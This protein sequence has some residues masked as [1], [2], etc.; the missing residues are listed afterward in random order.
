M[1]VFGNTFEI[2]CVSCGE[3]APH[4]VSYAGQEICHLHCS[5]CRAVNAYL[6]GPEGEKKVGEHQDHS[7]LMEP[8]GKKDQAYS[9][10]MAFTDGQYF[11]HPKFGCG[12][13]LAVA[14][15]PTKME[16]L[17]ED[18]KRVL[19]CGPDSVSGAKIA[20]AS[21][22]KAVFKDDDPVATPADDEKKPIECPICK[23]TVHPYNLIKSP[24]GKVVGCMHCR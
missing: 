2:S 1:I 24:N 12:Y 22:R 11:K 10:S 20:I 14:S 18:Q 15:P 8:K 23:K 5:A 9:A 4:N 21:K 16:V 7:A 17:F 13:V 3:K 6:A 19:V